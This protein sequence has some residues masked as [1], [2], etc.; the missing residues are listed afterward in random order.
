MTMEHPQRLRVIAST[1][2]HLATLAG[3]RRPTHDV[4]IHFAP[5]RPPSPRTSLKPARQRVIVPLFQVPFLPPLLP[6]EHK[7]R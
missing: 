4:L 1:F 7:V 5:L 3:S 2:V 6:R